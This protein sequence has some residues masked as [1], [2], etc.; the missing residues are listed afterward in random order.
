MLQAWA[1]DPAINPYGFRFVA[2]EPGNTPDVVFNALVDHEVV[3]L[4]FG[5]GLMQTYFAGANGNVS[6]RVDGWIATSLA[7]RPELYGGEV[8]DMAGHD[9]TGST[10]RADLAARSIGCRAERMDLPA[11]W[12]QAFDDN[13]FPVQMATSMF[14]RVLSRQPASRLYL[15]M[16]G[17]AAPAAPKAVEDEKTEL[18]VAWLDHVMRGAPFREPRVV[19]WARDAAVPV[20]GDVHQWPDSAWRR[21]TA[22]EWPPD[23]IGVREFWLG[24]D[25]RAGAPGGT[26]TAGS[27][28]LTVPAPDFGNDPVVQAAFGSDTARRRTV[29]TGADRDPAGLAWPCSGPSR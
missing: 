22:Q 24:A 17:H 11:Y 29:D 4:S 9:E 26:P 18:Q 21:L 6:P 8:C 25:G 3:K 5:V 16:G 28:P 14:D 23:G 12:M 7:D 10:M 27:I 20:A 1:D 2:L 15:S 19:Y 13:L